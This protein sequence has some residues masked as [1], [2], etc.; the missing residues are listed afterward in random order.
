[1]HSNAETLTP[2]Q[3]RKSLLEHNLMTTLLGGGVIRTQAARS[4]PRERVR[5]GSPPRGPGSGY[6][7]DAR[8]A[9]RGFLET[10]ACRIDA[11][12]LGA[13]AGANTC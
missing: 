10:I 2:N 3:V 4:E 12:F 7:K 6:L 9:M 5:L 13:P 11:R 8:T 1:M